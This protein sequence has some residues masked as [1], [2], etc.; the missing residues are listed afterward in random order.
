MSLIVAAISQARPGLRRDRHQSQ[1]PAP[2]PQQ[3]AIGWCVPR[4]LAT[5]PSRYSSARR[6]PRPPATDDGHRPAEDGPWLTPVVPR[7]EYQHAAST[8]DTAEFR[9]RCRLVRGEEQGVDAHDGVGLTSGERQIGERADHEP[10]SLGETK[11]LRSRRR[12]LNGLRRDVDPREH[13][14]GRRRNPQSWTSPTAPDVDGVPGAGLHD[15]VTERGQ[16]A[17]R[18][19]AVRVKTA[20]VL[21]GEDLPPD[22]HSDRRN[23]RGELSFEDR[24][25]IR[26]GHTPAL[27]R[28][29]DSAR[30]Q[31]VGHQY[32]TMATPTVGR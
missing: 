10:R 22:A 28:Q 9:D 12:L 2:R 7:R 30:E 27:P 1:P 3:A 5:D 14:A 32:L 19:E 18:H 21:S 29:P 20:R 4:G 26:V 13:R 17:A 6:N 8:S 31:S 23:R 11:C 15:H 25:P 16:F 24:P